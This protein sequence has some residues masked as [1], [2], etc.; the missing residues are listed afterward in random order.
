MDKQAEVINAVQTGDLDKL[1]ALLT[2]SPSLATARDANGV[3]AIMHALYRRRNDALD[4]LLT[5]RPDLDIFEA[6]SAGRRERVSELLR[7][8]RTLAAA[9]SADGFT[10]LHFAA[11]FGQEAVATLL[12]AHGGDAAA[13]ARNPMKVMPLH[14]AAAAHNLAIIRALLEH[15]APPN[16]RQEQGWTAIHE[17][18]QNGD[19]TMVE[20]LLKH[21]ADP[22][23]A[24]DQGIRPVDLAIK[25][26]HAEIA[27]LLQQSA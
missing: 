13:Q 15:G 6:T 25:N 16:A 17:A 7:R 3:S 24:N 9:W 12:L 23:L 26:G 10:A 5:A 21:G 14:S 11:F 8:D 20:L 19:K 22:S 27:K 18:A 2:Q 4:L 1:R